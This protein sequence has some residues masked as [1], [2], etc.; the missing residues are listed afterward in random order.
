MNPGDKMR[1]DEN[2]EAK[3]ESLRKLRR[4]PE[5]GTKIAED[6]YD[7]DNSGANSQY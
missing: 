7:P 6:L 2:D 3:N 1:F 4:I 5:V